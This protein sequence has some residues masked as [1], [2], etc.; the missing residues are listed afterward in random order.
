MMALS[1]DWSHQ[2]HTF[3][4]AP[5]LNKLEE[6]YWMKDIA[7]RSEICGS[8]VARPNRGVCKNHRASNVWTLVKLFELK[9]SGLC[10][11][12]IGCYCLET[13]AN[14]WRKAVPAGVLQQYT[15]WFSELWPNGA[16]P[17]FFF[18]WCFAEHPKIFLYEMTIGQFIML[19]F[20]QFC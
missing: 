10:H 18:P 7:P 11:Q 8:S 9:S 14:N 2:Y 19:V 12:H 16:E 13:T 1:T 15:A 3:S 4:L 17:A 6:F 5:Y 20:I